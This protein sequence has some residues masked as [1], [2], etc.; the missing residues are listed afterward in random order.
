MPAKDIGERVRKIADKTP[1][2]GEEQFAINQAQNEVYGIN[3]ELA[4]NLEQEKQAA[5]LLQGNNET[6]A[7]AVEIGVGG[8]GGLNPSTQEVLKKYGYQGRPEIKM[9]RPT[10]NPPTQGRPVIINNNYN[11][12]NNVVAGGD[13]QGNSS[14]FKTWLS[15]VFNRQKNEFEVRQKEY[16]RREWSLNRSANKMMRRM[17]SIS[18]SFSEQ[19]S[20][21]NFGRTVGS[22]L[23]IALLSVLGI[24]LVKHWKP[25]MK[26]IASIESGVKAFF[27]VDDLTDAARKSKG[28][29]F[30][31][32]IKEYLGFDTSP[33][34]EGYDKSVPGMIGTVLKEEFGILL[35]TFK[36]WMEKRG[37]AVKA[38]KF[39][40]LGLGSVAGGIAGE[41]VTPIGK[42][43]SG[44]SQYLGDILGAMISG[45]SS[46]TKPVGRHISE[47]SKN[48]TNQVAD[49]A[50]IVNSD[51]N[52][53][54]TI[55]SDYD[56]SG[57]IKNQP[58]SM[59]HATSEAAKNVK[60]QSK[61][62]HVAS[63]LNTLSSIERNVGEGDVPINLDLIRSLGVSDEFIDK[64]RSEDAVKIVKLKPVLAPLDINDVEHQL[65]NALPKMA[66]D[67]ALGYAKGWG[68]Q[69]AANFLS[70]GLTSDL[71][72]KEMTAGL[73]VTKSYL[74]HEGQRRGLLNGQKAIW[75]PVDDPRPPIGEIQDREVL[76]KQGWEKIKQELQ[77]PKFSN[78]N[79]EA[80]NWLKN[81][82]VNKK[83]N[84]SG[85][86][87]DFDEGVVTDAVNKQKEFERIEAKYDNIKKEKYPHAYK[88]NDNVAQ[89]AK[90]FGNWVSETASSGVEKIGEVFD[91]V[92][93]WRSKNNIPKEEVQ[94]RSNYIMKRL[95]NEFGLTPQQASG[96]VGNLIFESGGALDPQAENEGAYGIAQWRSDRLDEYTRL[97]PGK[98]IKDASFEEQVDFLMHELGN[99]HTSAIK[100]LKKV[101]NPIDAADVGLGFYEF[102]AGFEGAK[103]ALIKSGITEEQFNEHTRNRRGYSQLALNNY[104][105]LL[106]LKDQFNSI[107]NNSFNFDYDEAGNV[108]VDEQSPFYKKIELANQ[109]ASIDPSKAAQSGSYSYVDG[110]PTLK[111]TDE[112]TN[113]V[114]EVAPHDNKIQFYKR[115]FGA[116]TDRTG[117]YIEIDGKKLYLDLNKPVTTDLRELIIDPDKVESFRKNHNYPHNSLRARWDQLHPTF[118]T[119]TRAELVDKYIKNNL[120]QYNPGWSITGNFEKNPIYEK[121]TGR[122]DFKKV[123]DDIKE[124]GESGEISKP[125]TA[126]AELMSLQI[127][128][129]DETNQYL[130]TLASK[131]P[132][133]E[134]KV[135]VQGSITSSPTSNS[136]G[137]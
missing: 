47:S 98:H 54:F 123:A 34:S 44:I 20:P 115:A 37:M 134:K 70:L 66:W 43:L 41:I 108:K 124:A 30:V 48:T 111:S 64:L 65:P 121:L 10:G 122:I 75:V 23:K 25:I 7:Q 78:E 103:K 97:H 107:P 85:L 87:M 61:V 73:D 88:F 63:T 105:E 59:L 3:A 71:P 62:V 131:P 106:R 114:K 127:A 135:N 68:Y 102:S 81:F 16:R 72:I 24:L 84:K 113:Y 31:N 12:T 109:I 2:P 40:D 52:R 116:K 137:D 15:G 126:L 80:I 95:I 39:P 79:I 94:R 119:Y 32:K 133:V 9:N 100:N 67:G 19:M 22:Q 17:E 91:D 45:E 92:F 4:N 76:T 36:E 29:G 13:D 99:T 132:V 56:S 130:A 57:L 1:K 128:Q 33:G 129:T 136:N 120:D 51:A 38:V 58:S 28:V 90:D 8:G 35:E 89:S 125:L 18:K 110:V 118:D 27:G 60:D 117:S 14:K 74:L 26:S 93:K 46:L 42:A 83:E 5:A 69:K 112:I 82:L 55:G 49:K 50:K 86:V 104:S 11:T 96:I 101:N 21:Q 6:L 53:N 77:A